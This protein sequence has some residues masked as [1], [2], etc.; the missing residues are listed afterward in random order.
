MGGKNGEGR[1]NWPSA[2]AG[3]SIFSCPHMLAL[4][5]LGLRLGLKP[6]SLGLTVNYISLTNTK[7]YI[8]FFG[9]T[10]SSLRCLDFSLV[11]ACRLSCP[12][13]SGILVP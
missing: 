5:I 11:V 13:A 4:L 12:A 1:V 9:C 10:G 6:S 2:L 7:S 3:T 8:S